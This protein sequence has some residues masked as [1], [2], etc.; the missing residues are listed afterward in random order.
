MRIAKTIKDIP[1]STDAYIAFVG[2]G[3]AITI[4]L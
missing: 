1:R 2:I 3:I 4:E